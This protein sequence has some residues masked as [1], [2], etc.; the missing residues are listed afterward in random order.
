MSFSYTERAADSPYIETFWHLQTSSA[1]AYN[2]V[3]TSHSN[4]CL[5]RADG[6][7]H[8]KLFGPETQVTPRYFPANAEVLG[9]KFRLGTFM[10]HLPPD[11]LVNHILELPPASGHAFWLKGSAWQFPKFDD[12]DTFV[13]WLVRDGLLVRD[14]IVSVVLGGE[15]HDLSRRSV[16]YHFLAATGVTR[17]MIGRIERATRAATLLLQGV[18][19]QDVLQVSGYT[20]QPHLTR[21]LKHFLGQTPAKFMPHG[22][23]AQDPPRCLYVPSDGAD[24]PHSR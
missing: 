18:S 21:S 12:A 14:P 5:V 19:V 15:S 2:S 17:R 24:A 9:I 22:T 7:T 11:G 8:F 20:D 1:I 6:K 10:P 3:A 16:Q 4:F 23:E 13:A